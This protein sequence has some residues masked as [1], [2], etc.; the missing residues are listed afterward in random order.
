MDRLRRCDFLQHLNGK[1]FLSQ[2]QA[3]L[4]LAAGPSQTRITTSQPN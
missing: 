2:H 4:E 1:V 3:A